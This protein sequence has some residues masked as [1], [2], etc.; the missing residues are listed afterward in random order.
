MKINLLFLL[1]LFFILI[2]STNAC[3]KNEPETIVTYDTTYTNYDLI[4][5][6]PS[7]SFVSIS[8]EMVREYQDSIEIIISYRD[9]G[10]DLGDSD[11]AIRNLF[12]RDLRNNIVYAYRIPKLSPDG[13]DITVQGNFSV[14]ITNTVI[15]DGSTAQNVSYEL[16]IMDRSGHQSNILTSPEIQVIP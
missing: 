13:S 9:A 5:D 15:T 11:P 16:Y 2:L 8:P 4:S 6:T 1:S 7:I 10:G 12:V 3:K 14:Q